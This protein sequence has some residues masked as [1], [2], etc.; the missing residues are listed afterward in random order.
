MKRLLTYGACLLLPIFSCFAQ[1]PVE[2][3]IVIAEQNKIQ[4]LSF[5]IEP[6]NDEQMQAGITQELLQEIISKELA[7]H[8]IPVDPQLT[9]PSLVLKIRSIQVGLDIATFFQLQLYEQALL[10]RN[11]GLF[12]ATTWSQTALLSCPPEKLKQEVVETVTLLS[13]N[14]AKEYSKALSP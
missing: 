9:Q 14:F 5:R 2:D 13:Q 11:R 8:R 1:E 3:T 4:S 12:N 6:L 7:N 10:V